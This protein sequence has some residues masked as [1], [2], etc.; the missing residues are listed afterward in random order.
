MPFSAVRPAAALL[1]AALLAGC[2]STPADSPEEH[3]MTSPEPGVPAAKPL[4]AERR[5]AAEQGDPAAQ[6]E[7]ARELQAA[8]KHEEAVPWLEQA[9]AKH[10]PQ[11]LGLL[12]SARYFGHGAPQ[13]AGRAYALAKAAAEAG[14]PDGHFVLGRLHERGEGGATEDHALAVTHMTQAAERQHGDAEYNLAIWYAQGKVVGH[15]EARARSYFQRAHAHGVEQA[16]ERA[17]I[18]L[19]AGVFERLTQW[20]FRT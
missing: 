9:A 7:L 20:L 1:A 12:A 2:P 5:A 8:G 13:D 11:A 18:E 14:D 10:H 4:T 6:T 16:L 17:R 19:D 3:A 15:D